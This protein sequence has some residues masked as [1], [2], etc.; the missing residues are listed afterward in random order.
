MQAANEIVQDMATLFTEEPEDPFLSPLDRPRAIAIALVEGLVLR[1]G[2]ASAQIWFFDCSDA[3]FYS[4][5]Q[6]GLISPIQP[7]LERL[8]A[9]DSP[10]GQVI[11]QGQPLLIN[12]PEQQPWMP[13]PEW[14]RREGLQ[15]FAAYPMNLGSE[16]VGAFSLFSYVSLE[17]EM[18]EVLKLISSYAA[19]AIVN[20]RQ[21][22]QLQFQARRDGLIRQ[23]SQQLRQSLDRQTMLQTLVEQVGRALRVDQCDFLQVDWPGCGCS[24]NSSA[25]VSDPAVLSRFTSS[26]QIFLSAQVYQLLLQHPYLSQQWGQHHCL[27]VAN[28]RRSL[29]EVPDSPPAAVLL[30]PLL[31]QHQYREEMLGCLALIHG[32]EHVFLDAEIELTQAIAT[33]AALALNNA[34]LYAQTRQQGERETLLNRI[35][36]T[37]HHSL[38]WNEIVSTAMAELRDTLGLSRCLFFAVTADGQSVTVTFEVH[39]E[40][41]I[42]SEGPFALENFGPWT[43]Q[44]AQGECV[45]ISDLETAEDL[46]AAGRAIMEHLHNRAGVLIPVSPERSQGLDQVRL[47]QVLADQGIFSALGSDLE[48]E[49]QGLIGLVGAFKKH[50]YRWQAAEVELLQ[51]VA[52]QLAIALIRAQLF[53]HVRQQTERLALL[54]S[55]TAVIRAS[56]DPATLFHAITQQIGE[57]FEVEVCIL[58]LW[59]PED[60]CLRPVGIYAPQLSR[61]QL[62]E[63]LPG[64][65]LMAPLVPVA[66]ENGS[67]VASWQEQLRPPRLPCMI[68]E[69]TRAR[70]QFGTQMLLDQRAPV[71]LEDTTDDMG[72]L[73]VPLLQGD[74]LIGC[75]SLKRHIGQPS[76]QNP[77]L[78]L[79]EAVASQAA[80]AIDQVRLL[81]QTQQLLSQTQ[82]QARRE[83]LLNE[84]TAKI[85]TSLDPKQV[86][87]AIVKA[88]A[89][90]LDLDRCE[91]SLYGRDNPRTTPP[92]DIISPALVW[93]EGRFIKCRTPLSPQGC[94]SEPQ[95][96]AAADAPLEEETVEHWDW[97]QP[98]IMTVLE[99][100][101]PFILTPD[102]IENLITTESGALS[103]YLQQRRVHNLALIPIL[104]SGK[105]LGSIALIL[106]QSPH[107]DQSAVAREL[108]TEDLSLAMA[109]AEQAGIALQQAQLYEQTRI[110]A[111]RENLLRQ[112]A[113]R[114]SSTYDPAEI[115]E[116][117]L[118]SMANALQVDKCDFIALTSVS[119]VEPSGS[120]EIQHLPL[121]WVKGTPSQTP[122]SDPS[123]QHE[124][125]SIQQEYRRFSD[126]PSHLGQSL[127]PDLSWL[128]LLDCYG[129]HDSLLIED[130]C[131]FPLPP[132]T[133]RNLLQDQVQ[134]VLCV[135]VMTDVTRVA[136]V[137]C[138]FVPPKSDLRATLTT[139][140]DPEPAPEQQ[141]VS[142]LLC[143]ADTDLVQAL[144][145]ITAVALQ[146]AQ[147]Y[148]RAR[149]QETTAAAVR[150]LTEGREAES[151]RL[152]A[153]LHDQTLADLGALSRQMQNLAST[154][155]LTR[156]GQRALQEM[157]E[158]LCE[159]IAELRGIV[160]DLQPT[161]MRAFNL[162]SALRSLLERAAQRSSTP[163]VTRF[164]DRSADLLERLEPVAQSTLFRI[165]QEA[166]NNVVKHAR[167]GRIDITLVPISH[168][169]ASRINPASLTFP[170][171][172][173]YGIPDPKQWTHLE[174]KIIDDGVGMPE[175]PQGVGRHGLLNMRYRAE[176]INATIEW[177]GRRHGSGT[178]VQ[179]LIPLPPDSGPS[180]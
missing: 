79:A 4:V 26:S 179:I 62:E 64:L 12:H 76:W 23:I 141:P 158:Q 97:L 138:A 105:L 92:T 103:I 57:A 175:E 85:R 18:L 63:K 169:E 38:Q 9:D 28:L 128:I 178:V 78:K 25:G 99:R 55:M 5:A 162:G 58:A 44:V 72:V 59:Q 149:R 91:I 29:P 87:Q 142:R 39:D 160:E 19:S 152:A 133:R 109:V 17:P 81:T 71:I 75:I 68:P 122:P 180:V 74:D 53:E 126:I 69:S 31:L 117:A 98:E 32:E 136:G 14:I 77:D 157:N 113:Q 45:Q 41:L 148:E 88:L 173:G 120:P 119:E 110:S 13:A 165:V 94:P 129:R 80:I 86:L 144:A 90:T 134:A 137:M 111:L 116:I 22:A 24:E 112:V 8:Y 100:G 177:R 164:D 84:I 52:H 171:L 139:D 27:A 2:S 73:L 161:A 140:L 124:G 155:A 150:G 151:R 168:S 48:P 176:L 20:A 1:L 93:S 170:S 108:Q 65:T 127:S 15:A 101:H 67:D 60:S 118:E 6:R 104:Q 154:E 130:V 82:Q 172:A 54:H 89:T 123:S 131:H 83:S 115:I 61:D 102:Q 166:L 51:S 66:Q 50:P 121:K 16:P 46:P 145:D 11:K 43:Q 143:H 21:T 132:Q 125:L 33:Q 147:Y 35:T 174:V 36:N 49:Q 135:P 114:L 40:D 156:S 3:A 70:L 167:A 95:A 34:Q 163:L 7:Q 10:M 153:D 159:T 106:L 42:P 47:Q 56:L 30:V 107:M 96:F 37:L 146:R